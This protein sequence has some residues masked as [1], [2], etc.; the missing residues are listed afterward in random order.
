MSRTLTA[1]DRSSLIRLASSLPSGS[2]ERKAILAGLAKVSELGESRSPRGAILA[3]VRDIQRKNFL[4]Y[5]AQQGGK[6]TFTFRNQAL[7]DLW[8]NVF[9]GQI[10]DGMWEDDS[11]SGWQ[12][13]S[14]VQTRLGSKTTLSTQWLPSGVK[15]GFAFNRLIP[16]VGDYMLEV[17][18]RTE[19][20]A[21]LLT[22]KDYTR[23]I[24][25][26]MRAVSKG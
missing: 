3:G 5:L 24:M 16:V 26:A 15:N 21:T 18:Q 23:E 6:E 13:W 25:L 9:V 2:P 8:N 19:P 1:Q 22:V 17:V 12:Y 4:Q 10:S 11:N 7:M 20:S 14:S